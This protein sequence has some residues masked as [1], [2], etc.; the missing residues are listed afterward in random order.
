MDKHE[1]HVKNGITYQATCEECQKIQLGVF[2]KQTQRVPSSYYRVLQYKTV[3]GL[4][5]PSFGK[6]HYKFRGCP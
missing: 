1:Q 2:A 3:N 4:C 5:F 6:K